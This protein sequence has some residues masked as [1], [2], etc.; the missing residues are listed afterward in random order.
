[1]S[2]PPTE[3]ATPG[4][5]ASTRNVAVVGP[6]G[7]LV[8]PAALRRRHGLDPGVTLTVVERP[9][10]VLELHPARAPDAAASEGSDEFW[11][12]WWQEATLDRRDDDRRPNAGQEST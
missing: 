8:V 7:T 1:M 4:V 2:T 12:R 9:D 5:A 10:G 6:D 3:A 11:S